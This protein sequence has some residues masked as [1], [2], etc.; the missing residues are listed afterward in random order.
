MLPRNSFL[1]D[2]STSLTKLCKENII[3]HN[4][5]FKPVQ[6]ISLIQFAILIVRSVT[7]NF[8]EFYK[9]AELK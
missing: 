2:N 8:S 7:K 9:A 6:A 4:I 1:V 3:Y 5:E